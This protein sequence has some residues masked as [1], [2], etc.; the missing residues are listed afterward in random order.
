MDAL[1]DGR[2]GRLDILVRAGAD[3]PTATLTLAQD[4]GGPF[5]LTGCTVVVRA[6][7]RGDAPQNMVI[8]PTVVGDPADGVIALDFDETEIARMEPPST[9]SSKPR[10]GGD[11]TL[12]VVDAGGA[13][14]P[15]LYGEV[16]V[17]GD[18]TL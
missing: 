1:L 3:M 10:T 15:V 7:T 11:W 16:L 5:D 12:T 2:G 9:A 18:A 8:V 4:A 14:L 17:A 6:T 13:P